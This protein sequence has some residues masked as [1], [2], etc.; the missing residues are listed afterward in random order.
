MS[1]VTTLAR[2]VLGP[3]AVSFTLVA[4]EDGAAANDGETYSAYITRTANGGWNVV[5]TEGWTQTKTGTAGMDFRWRDIQGKWSLQGDASNRTGEWY[6]DT[7]ATDIHREQ[8]LNGQGQGGFA[9]SSI[10]MYAIWDEPAA[11]EYLYFF[12]DES[13]AGPTR[14]LRV[15]RLH[16]SDNGGVLETL[17]T[18]SFTDGVDYKCKLEV[19]GTSIKAFIDDVEVVNV[20]RTAHTKTNIRWTATGQNTTPAYFGGS[21]TVGTTYDKVWLKQ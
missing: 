8:I 16:P 6:T 11:A 9:G 19:D 7:G 5:N 13:G 20:T 12:I 10:G 17:H 18:Q 4:H 14:S 1:L 21:S 3:G 15:L 2:A